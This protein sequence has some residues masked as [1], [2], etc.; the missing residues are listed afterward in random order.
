M[1]SFSSPNFD[2]NIVLQS[3]L[4]FTIFLTVLMMHVW[5][6]FFKS[7]GVLLY[8]V[9]WFDYLLLNR[10]EYFVHLFP[11]KRCVSK[12]MNSSSNVHIIS[13][14]RQRNFNLL[15]IY[16]ILFFTFEIQIGY[17]CLHCVCSESNSHLQKPFNL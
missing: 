7:F 16:L 2:I 3:N 13:S 4:L 14:L 12:K 6:W 9:F 8:L 17:Y 11:R 10:D 15:L 5:K 1:M